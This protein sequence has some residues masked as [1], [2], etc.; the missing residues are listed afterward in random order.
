[1]SCPL[2]RRE[3]EGSMWEEAVRGTGRREAAIRI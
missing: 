3:E 2:L 1:V